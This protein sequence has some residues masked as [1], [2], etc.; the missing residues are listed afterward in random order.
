MVLL[1]GRSN[2]PGVG[3]FS[4]KNL[5]SGFEKDLKATGLLLLETVMISLTEKSKIQSRSKEAIERLVNDVFRDDFD[6]LR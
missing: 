2:S 5:S 4:N 1:A 3:G 6:G